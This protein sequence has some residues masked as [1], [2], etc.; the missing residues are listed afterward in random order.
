VRL[1]C[2]WVKND[3]KMSSHLTGHRDCLM[4]HAPAP[5]HYAPA[6]LL[7]A[8]RGSPCPLPGAYLS[9]NI[10]GLP[11]PSA[12]PSSRPT[13]QRGGAKIG[14]RLHLAIKGCIS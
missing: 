12:E 3:E 6:A 9:L 10:S 14:Q 11:N 2:V 13:S 1:Q 8:A 5:R 4:S 7:R